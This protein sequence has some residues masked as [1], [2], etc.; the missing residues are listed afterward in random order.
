MKFRLSRTAVIYFSVILALLFVFIFIPLAINVT[1]IKESKFEKLIGESQISL[2]KI[3][4]KGE[5]IIYYIDQSAML[6]FVESLLSLSFQGGLASPDCG[7]YGGYNMWNSKERESY[8]GA[9][10]ALATEFNARLNEYL[11]IFP[12]EPIPE[13]PYDITIQSK[14]TKTELIAKSKEDLRMDISETDAYNFKVESLKEEKA[15]TPACEGKECGDDGCGGSCGS[16]SE[17]EKCNSLGKCYKEDTCTPNCAGK[18]CG[19]NGCGGSCG[20]CGSGKT[21]NPSGRCV[22][23]GPP[24]PTSSGKCGFLADYGGEYVEARCLYSL[25]AAPIATPQRCNEHG[26]TC[27]TFVTSVT[28]LKLGDATHGNGNQQCNS[29]SVTKIGKEPSILQ[30]GDIFSSEVIYSEGQRTPWGHT[31]MYVGRGSLVSGSKGEGS[32]C[33]RQYTPNANGDYIF[34]HSIGGRN[35]GLPGVCYDTYDHLLGPG[36]IFKLISF[37]R[38][39]KCA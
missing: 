15:C 28:S 29:A 12:K 16:C 13:I 21:C 11:K 5:K 25:D 19:D 22:N 32:Y 33:W 2:L 6:A 24:Q 37:C 39:K 18:E 27:A 35:L 9:K 14:D 38:P 34:A 7:A 10:A 17:E 20:T 23:D 4:E 31:G 26:L 3:Y 8:P 1:T 30:P 36:S